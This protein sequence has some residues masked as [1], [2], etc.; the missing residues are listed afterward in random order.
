MINV[1]YVFTCGLDLNLKEE[2]KSEIFSI[3]IF[4]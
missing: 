2:N 4:V 3:E 1:A